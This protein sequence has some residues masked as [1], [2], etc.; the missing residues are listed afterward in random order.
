MAGVSQEPLVSLKEFNENF[1]FPFKYGDTSKPWPRKTILLYKYS[2]NAINKSFIYPENTWKKVEN[3]Q[4][5]RH[6][7]VIMIESLRSIQDSLEND[8]CCP[9][10][11]LYEGIHSIEVIQSYSP[12]SSCSAELCSFKRTLDEKITANRIARIS[13]TTNFKRLEEIKFQITFSN[14]YMH[15]EKYKDGKKTWKD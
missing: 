12:C 8:F 2:S 3:E 15:T 1:A 13:L 5:R 4:G 7:E 10:Q 6:A 9:A 14:F 11:S